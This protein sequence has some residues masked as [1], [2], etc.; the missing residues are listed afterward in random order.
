M[1]QNLPFSQ[2]WDNHSNSVALVTIYVECDERS[3][4]SSQRQ[5]DNAED[6]AAVNMPDDIGCLA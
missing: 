6:Y 2:M 5:P 1:R 4:P 3:V